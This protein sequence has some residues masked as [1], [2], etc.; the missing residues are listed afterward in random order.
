MTGFTI[1]AVDNEPGIWKRT[2][3]PME[4]VEYFFSETLP[5]G[6]KQLI[7]PYETIKATRED[8]RYYFRSK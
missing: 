7:G 3:H 8:Q 4:K 5:N 1:S 6:D 2:T